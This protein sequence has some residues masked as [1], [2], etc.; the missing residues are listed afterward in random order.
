[1]EQI[2]KPN[3]MYLSVL[4]NAKQSGGDYRLSQYS[5]CQH[6]DDGYLLYNTLTREI[7]LLTDEEYEH[8][9]ETEY[10]R[11]NWFVVPKELDELIAAKRL[12]WF[13][14]TMKKETG[15]IT[16][17]TILPTTDCNARCFYCFELGHARKYMSDE[18]AVKTVDYI[19]NHCGGNE[20]LLRW[21]GGEPLY[22]YRAIDII[23]DE[24]QKRGIPYTSKMISNGYLF[25]EELISKCIN[26]WNLSQVQ[27]T[28]DG[29]QEVY[30]R[31]K[32]YIYKEGNP[33]QIVMGNIQRLLDQN[34]K[35]I[36]R[37]NMDFHNISD[38]RELTDELGLRF[39]NCR[40][41]YLYPYLIFDSKVSWDQRYSLEQWEILYSELEKLIQKQID[42]G[43][44]AF[45]CR[46][47]KNSLPVHH[48]IADSDHAVVIL[49]DGNLCSCENYTDNS[50]FGHIDSAEIDQSVIA[51]WRVHDEISECST[52]FYFPD[53][54]RL[55][56]C[57]D[58]VKCNMFERN[59]RLHETQRA[60][61]NEYILWK[62]H[63]ASEE[64]IEIE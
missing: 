45:R 53:C 30:N 26:N 52:C 43:F 40:N 57:T 11:R 56:K 6:V 37:M 42:L 16:T 50:F 5:V 47:V 25:N 54:I 15:N 32:A 1:M 3:G 36:I 39:G 24:L 10:L 49:P 64:S 20:V 46:R 61:I 41:L 48:C 14:R 13:N 4:G 2:K 58:E 60:V 35:V 19:A 51:S 62:K 29:T 23:C 55:K 17:Y 8:V 12:I 38:L 63:R 18:M 31:C 9:L 34:L 27:I 59:L 33:Y 7:V 22:H 21:F 28:L 44:Y